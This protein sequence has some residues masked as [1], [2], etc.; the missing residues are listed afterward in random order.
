MF[1]HILAGTENDGSKDGDDT[2]KPANKNVSLGLRYRI[3]LASLGGG[4][5]EC[6]SC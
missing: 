5:I 3:L 1:L 4:E 2:S 6:F